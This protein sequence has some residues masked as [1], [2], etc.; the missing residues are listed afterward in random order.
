MTRFIKGIAL[1]ATMILASCSGG[2][3]GSKNPP[4]S[5]TNPV[6]AIRPIRKPMSEPSSD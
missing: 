1:T 3:G 4:P 2:G 6:W 5:P